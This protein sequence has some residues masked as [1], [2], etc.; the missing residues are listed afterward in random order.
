MR[1]LMIATGYLPYTFS[2]SLCNA[3]LVYA[4]QEAGIEVDVISRKGEGPAYSAKWE[5][6]WLGLQHTTHEIQYPIGGQLPRAVDV[7]YSGWKMGIYNEE[8]IR[9]AR[10]AYEKA[11]Q[12]INKHHYNAILTRSP[13]DPPHWV[14]YKLKKKT[15]I[16]WIANWNDPASPIWPEP[17]KYHCSALKQNK[18]ERYTER[19]LL[20]ADINSFPC[21]ALRQ[22]FMHHFPKLEYKRTEVI[23]HI[24]FGQLSSPNPQPSIPKPSQK[25]RLCHSGNLSLERNPELLFQAI[26]SLIDEGQ[27]MITLDIMGQSNPFV[28]QLIIKHHLEQQ[29]RIIGGLP[30]LEAMER[31]K[32][33]DVLVLLEAIMEKG[34]FFASKFTDYAQTGRPILAL[35]PT[36]GFAVSILTEHGGGF[37]VDNSN[38]DSIKKGLSNLLVMKQNDSLKNLS[39]T[40]LY[41]VFKPEKI[42]KQYVSLISE[43]CIPH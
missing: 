30:F 21:D 13:S 3:K 4:L 16:R 2:E 25:L 24:G 32:N 7:L 15:G 18:L 6:P 9:W 33:Y 12:L 27:D 34:I 42:V 26:R 39:S 22:H 28:E 14:G 38:P 5:E 31:L 36:E 19:L 41:N 40:N 17:Y 23:P 11:I 43:S 29:V 35:S 20:A 8:G 37:A 10:R 1:L